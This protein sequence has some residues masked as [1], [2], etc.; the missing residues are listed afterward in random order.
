MDMGYYTRHELSIKSGSDNLIK[1]LREYSQE[2]SYALQDNGDT[3]ESCKWYG[4]QDELRSFSLLHPEALF[5]LEGEGEESCDIWVEYYQ[6]G[7]MQ[8][9][10]AKISFDGFDESLLK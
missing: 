4:H 1:E 8:L 3:E 9:C 7:K 6:N 10:K 5:K 2:A